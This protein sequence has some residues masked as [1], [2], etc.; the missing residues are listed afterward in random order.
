M[1]FTFEW[2]VMKADASKGI[3]YHHVGNVYSTDMKRYYGLI[4]LVFAERWP[5]SYYDQMRVGRIPTYGYRYVERLSL[6]HI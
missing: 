2:Q 1:K 3:Q 4:T 5:E 6:I